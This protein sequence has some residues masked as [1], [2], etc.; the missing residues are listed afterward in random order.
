ML[1]R[2]DALLWAA[3]AF[4]LLH[5]LGLH[6]GYDAMTVA[7]PRRISIL[8]ATGSVGTSTL[9]LIEENPTAFTVEALTANRDVD[10][11]AA[12]ARRVGAKL[13]VVADPAAYGVLKAA[14]SG[15]GIEV[16]AGD[17]R[18]SSR[19]RPVRPIW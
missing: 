16:A 2:I 17:P 6:L 3:P 1:D 14:L 8:G 11:L 10:S 12:V 9:G 18:R 4:A 19:L 7:K 5:A 15:S 13:A